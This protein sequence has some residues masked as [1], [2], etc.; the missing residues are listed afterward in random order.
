MWGFLSWVIQPLAPSPLSTSRAK[1]KPPEQTRASPSHIR[2]GIGPGGSACGM[3]P[4]AIVWGT[5]REMSLHVE[6]GNANMTM[7]T[8]L[9]E[10]CRPCSY[11]N[12]CQQR[13]GQT[14][15]R[16]TVYFLSGTIANSLWPNPACHHFCMTHELK[17]IL[18]FFFVSN[19][20]GIFNCGKRHI[21]TFTIL[22][23]F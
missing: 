4:E 16:P 9:W 3:I 7:V 5:G 1:R 20:N 23:I 6:V 11:P 2:T 17:L 22:T 13:S 8:S 15:H 21:T 14:K 12:A 10:N 19:R 18:A